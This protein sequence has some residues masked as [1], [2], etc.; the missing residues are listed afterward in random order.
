MIIQDGSNEV[1]IRMSQ[2]ALD[3]AIQAIAEYE[4]EKC[5]DSGGDPDDL[6]CVMPELRALIRARKRLHS[7]GVY[8]GNIPPLRY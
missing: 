2:R 3:A 6:E 5:F 8:K 1:T 4:P 7:L